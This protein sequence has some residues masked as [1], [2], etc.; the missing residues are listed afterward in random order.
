MFDEQQPLKKIPY[1]L[2]SYR[3]VRLDNCY[4][5]DKTM[6]IP[7]LENMG[8]YLMFIRPRRFGKSLFLSMLECYYD[9]AMADQFEQLFKGTAIYDA[10]TPEKNRYLV[11]SFNFS[12]VNPELDKLDNS[13]EQYVGRILLDFGK[14]YRQLIGDEYFSTLE[15]ATGIQKLQFAL[16]YIGAQ[17]YRAYILIDEYD[18]FTNTI[19]STKGPLAYREVTHGAGFYRFFFNLI[20]GAA[21]TNSSGVARLFITGVS[22]VTMD[23]VTS[24]FNIGQHISLARFNEMLGF[25]EQDVVEMLNYY[26]LPV[27]D[28]LPL[29]RVWYNNYRFSQ[30]ATKYLYNTDMVLY[31]INHYLKN[32][33]PPEEMIDQ[34]IKTDYG[35]LRHLM[36]LDKQLNGNF[37]YLRHIVETRQ[38]S[39]PVATSFPMEYLTKPVNFISLLFYFG[40][41]SQADDDELMVPNETVLQLLYSYLR[42]GYDDVGIFRVDVWQLV[43]LIKRMAYFG[44]W[45][46]VFEFL[47]AEVEKQTSIRDYLLGE[48]VIQT[49]LLAYLNVADYYLTRTEHEM[50]K[51]FADLYL[52]PFLAKNERVKYSYV[53]ELKYL[54]RSEFS[55]TLLQE[56][57]TEAKTQLQQYAQDPRVH[58]FGDKV[59]L[60]CIAMVYCGWELKI[61]EEVVIC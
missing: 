1:G 5:L 22:P 30:R 52:E 11:L 46:A 35:K 23:D 28:L 7:Q 9:V 49:F 19:M 56:K 17:G 29:M 14:K 42:D 58:G 55:E 48:K 39:G 51:G 44:E 57:L 50:G 40:L 61:M 15:G 27:A 26:A 4:Y 53:I 10:P 12:Q 38:I 47:A 36:V 54:T 59:Q 16:D 18:N 2:A 60:K 32:N 34:N 8:K 31:F 43:N 45:R 13:F 41:L 24:G 37:S 33:D 20:K 6:Y 25:T 3:D 21:G